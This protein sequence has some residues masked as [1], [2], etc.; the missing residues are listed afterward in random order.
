MRL[1]ID[2]ELV[3]KRSIAIHT[4]YQ[5]RSYKHVLPWLNAGCTGVTPGMRRI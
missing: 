2:N 1:I 5:R 4:P 3:Q